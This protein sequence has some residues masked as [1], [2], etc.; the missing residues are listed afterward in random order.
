MSIS[1]YIIGE[2]SLS[3]WGLSSHTR[4]TRALHRI[5]VTDVVENLDALPPATTVLLVRATYLYD[6]RVLKSLIK[7]HNILLRA[8]SQG[9]QVVVAAIV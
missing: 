3:L 9:H 7:E 8:P 1:A 5:G 4:L 2:S 6:E